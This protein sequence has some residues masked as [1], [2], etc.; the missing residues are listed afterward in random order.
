MRING[1]TPED[2]EGL[3][4]AMD[5]VNHDI[6]RE[7]SESDNVE[8]EL[9]PVVSA[10]MEQELDPVSEQELSPVVSAVMEQELDP[11]VPAVMEQELAPVSEQELAPVSAVMGQELAPVSEQELAPVSVQELCPDDVLMLAPVSEQELA[12]VSAVM[13]QEL[14]PV[15]EQELAPVSVQELCPDD[16]LIMLK[17]RME[18]GEKARFNEEIRVQM[19]LNSDQKTF[20]ALTE[21]LT[22]A[23][24]D[25]ELVINRA[26]K[27][28]N[29]W[30]IHKTT[31]TVNHCKR[32][33][34]IQAMWNG[35][36]DAHPSPP[37]QTD[38]ATWLSLTEPSL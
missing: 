4:D 2:E 34:A 17:T 27:A 33:I 28:E 3:R 38:I 5:R 14:A 22:W 16:V 20:W 31:L 26:Q 35:I 30:Q 8:Q 24:R 6:I 9:S 37:T 25:K 10:V 12:P 18:I 19:Q 7:E 11:I 32:M 23:A 15:S 1:S 36:K 13:G 29:G 21:S